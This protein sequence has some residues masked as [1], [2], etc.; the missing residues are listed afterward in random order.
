MVCMASLW[1]SGLFKT[2][3]VIE[4]DQPVSALAF[5]LELTSVMYSS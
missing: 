5:G 2:E 1:E 4:C 3:L